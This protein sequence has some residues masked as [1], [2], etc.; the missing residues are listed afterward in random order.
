MRPITF[1]YTP[2]KGRVAP[3]IPVE[4]SGPRGWVQVWTYV[5]SGATF[6]ILGAE[7]GERLGLPIDHGKPS[8]IVVGDGSLIPVYIHRLPIR[9][10]PVT[11]EA[12]I[13]T[14]PRLGVGF[15]LL[16]R[17]DIF[18]RFDVTFSDSRRI[19]TFAPVS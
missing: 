12:H 5:D 14:S 15:D 17:Q 16:G 18:T 6:S 19:I 3:I 4:L 11:F 9:I 7:S 1:P 2:Y 10:G 13:G 8:H